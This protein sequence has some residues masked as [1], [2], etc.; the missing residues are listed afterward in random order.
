MSAREGKPAA[1]M[2]QKALAAYLN[3][4]P[5]TVSLVLN[6]APL[7]A[8]IPEQTRQRVIEAA[9]QFDYRPNLYAKYLFS[10]KSYT[11][12]VLLPEIGE[13]FSSAILG[14]VDEAL[15]R[16]HYA[17]F[18]ANHH[19]DNQL[20]REFPRQL[21]QRAV[22]GYILINTAV[23]EPLEAPAVSIGNSPVAGEIVRIRVDHEMGGAMAAE[24]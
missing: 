22:E 8:A 20:I 12:A 24:H 5:S 19:G 11:V 18:I 4:S 17:F 16:K 1:R 21:A 10:K 13:G 14:G 15:V 23:D 6:N 7:A 2:S 3:L 9:R